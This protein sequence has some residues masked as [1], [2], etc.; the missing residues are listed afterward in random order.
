MYRPPM[1]SRRVIGIDTGGTKL[2]G[3]VVDED[4]DGTHAR[5]PAVPRRSREE[6]LDDH[7]R[8]PWRRPARTAPDVEAVGFGIPS[9]VDQRKGT[10]VTSVHL[11]IEDV[12]FRD[13][14]T[15]R[16]GLPVFMDNDGNLAALAEQRSGAAR[17]ARARRAAHPR[18]GHRRRA[19]AR[20]QGLPRL[21]R[22]GRRARA[23]GHRLR[24]AALPGQLP[25][26][27]LPGGARLG[28]GDRPRGHPR[29]PA[30]P[31]HGVVALALRGRR[32]HGRAS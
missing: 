28:H 27:G 17:G 30:Q 12:P 29:R 31:R 10:S 14:M 25:E 3:G 9:L 20:R 24:R 18:H 8:T 21:D 15:E 19:R 16:L 22:R 32:H 13:I 5:A 26:P 2:L 4:A 23:H 11:P 7:G 6:A 1:A